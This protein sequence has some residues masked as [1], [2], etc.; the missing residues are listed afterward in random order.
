MQEA[1]ETIRQLRAVGHQ[2]EIDDFGTGYSSLVY[3]KDLRVD[4]IKIDKAFTQ[5]IGTEAVIGSLLPQ[6]LAMAEALDLNVIAEG[7]ETEAQADFFAS[8]R[9]P[10][11][12]QGWHF[13][14]PIPAEEFRQQHF[15]STARP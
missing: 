4:A 1:V 11:Q 7:I 12:G 14:R 8:W 9:F 5:T 10:V 3:L 2:V 6:I 13:G 15:G